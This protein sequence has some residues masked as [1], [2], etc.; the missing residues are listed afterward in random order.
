MFRSSFRFETTFKC[1]V[2]TTMILPL[3][4][5]SKMNIDLI[6]SA[7]W[8][9]FA[10]ANLVGFF[11]LIQLT[12]VSDLLSQTVARDRGFS[13]SAFKEITLAD[14]KKFGFRYSSIVSVDGA[15]KDK[16]RYSIGSIGHGLF[17]DPKG[18]NSFLSLG[19]VSYSNHGLALYRVSTDPKVR[20]ELLI[21][22]H[23]R[24]RPTQ[25]SFQQAPDGNVFVISNQ[26]L[27]LCLKEG[28]TVERYAIDGYYQ[29]PTM[30]FRPIEGVVT[31]T[32]VLFYSAIDSDFKGKALR[33]LIQYKDGKFKK[34][35]LGESG[36]SSV[37]IVGDNKLTFLRHD[38]LKSIDIETG[39]ISTKPIEGP[40][41]EG[42][43]LVPAKIFVRKNGEMI[44]L[45]RMPTTKGSWKKKFKGE[46]LNQFA[47]VESGK[48]VLKDMGLDSR[49]RKWTTVFAEDNAGRCWFSG[50]GNGRLVVRQPDG[51][52]QAVETMRLFDNRLIEKIEFPQDKKDQVNFFLTNGQ[53]YERSIVKMLDRRPRTY[54]AWV[55]VKSK[56]PLIPNASGTLYG[57]SIGKNAKLLKVAGGKVERIELPP[58]SEWDSSESV[59]ITTDTK[60]EVWLFS[61]GQDK[62]A[63]FDGSKWKT[64]GPKK[65]NGK[66][67]T[68]KQVALAE[69]AAS[70]ADQTGGGNS[71]Y[72]IGLVGG[73]RVQFGPDGQVLYLNGIKR[74]EYFDGENWHAPTKGR[75]VGRVSVYGQPFFEDGCIRFRDY[76]NKYSMTTNQFKN[77]K[78]ADGQRP[79]KLVGPAGSIKKYWKPGKLPVSG[80][81][82]YRSGNCWLALKDNEVYIAREGQTWSKFSLFDTPIEN[83]TK[84]QVY[85]NN[86]T[87][88]IFALDKERFVYS[89]PKITISPK[90][91]LG[92]FDKPGANVV[93]EFETDPKGLATRLRYRIAD[94]PWTG[95]QDSNKPIFLRAIANSG[96]HQVEVQI[97]VDE[98]LVKSSTVNFEFTT[99]YS[100]QKH[101]NEQVDLLSS[102]EFEDRDAAM[103]VLIGYGPAVLPTIDALSESEDTETRVRAKK[104]ADAVRAKLNPIKP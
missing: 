69:Q 38:G 6:F 45:W 73:F 3:L 50:T 30:M 62:V 1:Y 90:L 77:M 56:T 104:I 4:V 58:S 74:I 88:L 46:F 13:A 26:G 12:L 86:G 53:A 52:Y 17:N 81:R 61:D 5:A 36:L 100:L 60:D 40:T 70:I 41:F 102:S 18:E 64:Y 94:D 21:R 37:K 87:D 22:T 16:F 15:V 63:K 76:R 55:E 48:W 80:W 49:S 83:A 9:R 27:L 34:I 67:W 14:G 39:E 82:A 59:Y 57:I 35:E 85:S 95:W 79:W 101:I 29:D 98:H 24:L 96:K 7:R 65:Q 72:K 92:E 2:N 78:S 8:M 99:T 10:K 28:K 31:D 47:E 42:K 91:S 43:K 103:K 93:P 33:D 54:P 20:P 51:E 32:S 68:A 44:S 11:C 97:N 19:Q 84:F 89:P 75:E 71:E 66:S 25:L 23:E